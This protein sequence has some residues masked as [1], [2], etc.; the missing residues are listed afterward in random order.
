VDVGVHAEA[1]AALVIREVV[2]VDGLVGVHLVAELLVDLVA[3]FQFLVVEAA[4]SVQ[5]VLGRSGT[6]LLRLLF[7][8]HY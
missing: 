5:D 1:N 8:T 7:L 2:F 3:G 4:L 6:C